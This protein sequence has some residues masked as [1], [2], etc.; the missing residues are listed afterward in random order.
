MELRVD[1]GRAGTACRAP[2]DGDQ[3]VLRSV[4]NSCF[5]RDTELRELQ[6]RMEQQKVTSN[7]EKW[8]YS[9]TKLNGEPVEVDTTVTVKYELGR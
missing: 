1:Y 3:H 5:A 4:R 2:T 7:L 9:P 8:R 6:Q